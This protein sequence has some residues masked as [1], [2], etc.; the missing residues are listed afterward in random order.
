MWNDA[1]IRHDSE[2]LDANSDR[3][4]F[5]DA[6][7]VE[8]KVQCRDMPERPG[9]I[10]LDFASTT[11]KRRSAQIKAVQLDE[12]RNLDDQAWRTL[13]ADAGVIELE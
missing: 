3:I 1:G 9:K 7:G 2:P 12:L 6:R 11:G 4:G 13:L 8:W 5:V 10:A